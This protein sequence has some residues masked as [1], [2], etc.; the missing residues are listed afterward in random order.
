MTPGLAVGPADLAYA[1]G[2]KSRLLATPTVARPLRPSLTPVGGRRW[3]SAE[4]HCSAIG[5]VADLVGVVGD[6]GDVVGDLAD[7][8][9]GGARAVQLGFR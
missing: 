6:V 5:Q 8:P 4:A 1:I 9:G 2:I 3:S 7:G